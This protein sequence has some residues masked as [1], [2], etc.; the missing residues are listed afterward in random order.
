MRNQP[1]I[2]QNIIQ[3]IQY[4]LIKICDPFESPQPIEVP[5]WKTKAGPNASIKNML[6]LQIQMA[7]LK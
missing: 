4:Q 5:I 2:Y 3:L 7:W 1:I 6:W